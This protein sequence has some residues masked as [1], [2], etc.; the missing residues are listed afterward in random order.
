MRRVPVH[1]DTIEEM[2]NLIHMQEAIEPVIALFAG[3]DGDTARDVSVGIDFIARLDADPRRLADPAARRVRD[4]LETICRSHDPKY[5]ENYLAHKRTEWIDTPAT[6]LESARCVSGSP[7]SCKLS[8]TA[9]WKALAAPHDHVLGLSV[10][11][12]DVLN[13]LE[14]IVVEGRGWGLDDPK[15]G[16]HISIPLIPA[17]MSKRGKKASVSAIEKC[18][19]GLCRIG[20]IACVGY[21]EKHRKLW[22]P[23]WDPRICDSPHAVFE[24]AARLAE[25]GARNASYWRPVSGHPAIDPVHHV[26]KE[27]VA[28]IETYRRST[29]ADQADVDSDHNLD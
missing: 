18:I 5:W 2:A 15:K 27:V 3:M 7:A 9:K 11:E 26:N 23:I 13:L 29:F 8:V 21:G 28:A 22:T 6:S 25:A 4:D 24:R 1:P 20:L 12:T 16:R 10:A 17:R 19:P 14:R